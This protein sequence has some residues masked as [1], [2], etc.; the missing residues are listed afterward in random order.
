MARV[1]LIEERDH[2]E[3]AELIGK[4]RGGLQ[5]RLLHTYRAMLNAPDLVGVWLDYMGA[6][7]WKTEIDG[8][9]REILIIRIA[10][11]NGARYSMRQHV[12]KVA[13]A[14]GLTLEECE[15]LA[16]WRATQLF[17]MRERAALDY[18][19]AMTQD[20]QV[21]AAVYE[22]LRT[23]FTDRQLVELTLLIAAYNMQ[24]R[25][26]EALDVDLEP[27]DPPASDTT[28]S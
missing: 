1:P 20:I 15:R 28:K 9:L 2:P 5:G 21:P 22:P 4:V 12:P 24:N 8:R 6:V 13:L 26:V 25:F 11:L 14:E 27:L 18:A 7:R 17:D 10:H 3:L 19:D 16:D 23:Y